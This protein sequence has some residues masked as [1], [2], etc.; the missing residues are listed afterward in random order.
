MRNLW[1]YKSFF[2]RNLFVVYGFVGLSILFPELHTNFD[3]LYRVFETTL[4]IDGR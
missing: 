2:H 1:V 3:H 4:R